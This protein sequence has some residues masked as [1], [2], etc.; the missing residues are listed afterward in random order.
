MQVIEG[1]RAMML[2]RHPRDEAPQVHD[3]IRSLRVETAGSRMSVTWPISNER[4][5]QVI[6]HRR[7]NLPHGRKPADRDQAD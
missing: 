5:I 4:M 1:F 3:A 2:L 7:R 6:E